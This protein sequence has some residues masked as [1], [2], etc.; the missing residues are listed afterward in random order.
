MARKILSVSEN[1]GGSGGGSFSP[2]GRTSPEVVVLPGVGGGALVTL[3]LVGRRRLVVLA[4]LVLV[5]LGRVRRDVDA[6]GGDRV[7]AGRLDVDRDAQLGRRLL[8]PDLQD[9]R[10]GGYVGE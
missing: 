7:P 3:I 4:V 5:R 6:D 8:V 2:F 1:R 10:P 9:V